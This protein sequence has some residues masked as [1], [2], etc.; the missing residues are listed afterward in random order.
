VVVVTHMPI[1]DC[2]ILPWPNNPD[3]G[4]MKGYF[5][6]LTLGR[7]VLTHGKVTHLLSGHT[8]KGYDGR[9]QLPGGRRVGV[10]V[11]G[12]AEGRPRWVPL[13]VQAGNGG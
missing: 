5:G 6:N 9:L 4:F 13:V 1:L 11:V 10:H 7:E 2:Q 8:H 12:R 3:W